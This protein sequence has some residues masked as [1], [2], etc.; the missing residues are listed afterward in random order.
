MNTLN[1][2]SCPNCGARITLRASADCEDDWK[3]RLAKLVSCNQCADFF[4][5]RLKIRERI[6][7]ITFS[8][9]RE[10][11]GEINSSRASES[12]LR[13]KYFPI[14]VTETKQLS[15]L[16]CEFYNLTNV[17]EPEFAEMIFDKPNFISKI[18]TNYSAGLHRE[19]GSKN[20]RK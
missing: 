5:A 16:E 11:S 2:K 20:A 10:K 8:L 13:S 1:F 4:Q 3:H 18:L 14:I 15:T 9:W 19:S 12:E 17:W 6:C 7:K